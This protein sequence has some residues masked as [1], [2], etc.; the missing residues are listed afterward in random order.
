MGPTINALWR[1]L[2]AVPPPNAYPRIIP[3]GLGPMEF[4]RGLRHANR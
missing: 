1:S 4:N 2:K 3:M